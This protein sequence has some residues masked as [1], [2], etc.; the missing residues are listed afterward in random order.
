MAKQKPQLREK[1]NVQTVPIGL[2]KEYD[3]LFGSA[4][5]KLVSVCRERGF[6]RKVRPREFG[7]ELGNVYHRVIHN[8]RRAYRDANVREKSRWRDIRYRG[9]N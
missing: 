6:E 2:Q 4:W 3:E 9:R 1:D 5:E 7:T 8:L